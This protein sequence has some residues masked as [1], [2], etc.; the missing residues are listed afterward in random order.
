[1]KAVLR[2]AFAIHKRRDTGAAATVYQDRC[3]LQRR[4]HRGLALQPTTPHGRR[5]QKRDAK[6]QDHVCLLLDDAAIPPTH[7]SSAHT[8]RMR[9]VVRKVT[10]GFRS[11]WGRDLLAAVRSGVNT[12]KRQGLSAYQAIQKALAP[13]GSLGEPG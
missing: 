7:H 10:N 11:D 8:I 13:I 6:I 9:T 3:D 1:M 2:R 5:L 4:V 12:G